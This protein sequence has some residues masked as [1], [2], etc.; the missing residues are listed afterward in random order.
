[1]AFTIPNEVDAFHADQAEP[2]K[3]DIDVLVAA[4]SGQ[5]VLSGAAVT[6][7]GSPDMTVAVAA[8]VVRIGGAPV[9]V[10]SGNVT[11]TSA[12]ATN[13]RFDLIAVDSS[14]TKSA[15]AGSPAAQP[16][17][18]AI[19]AS[20]V[21]LAAVYVPATDTTIASNQITD[22]RAIVTPNS[23]IPISSTAAT[24]AGA[25]QTLPDENAS[26]QIRLRFTVPEWWNGIS[27]I[28]VRTIWF[29]ASTGLV[30]LETQ[31]DYWTE[32][33]EN[34]TVALQAFTNS[35]LTWTTGSRAKVLTTTIAAASVA[36]NRH[37]QLAFRRNTGDANTGNLFFLGA[38]INQS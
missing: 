24:V 22:K 21:I 23:S 5:G 7:Q 4:L 12:D 33:D 37:F 35:N 26:N 1:M 20:S 29:A 9:Q 14:G 32:V 30:D 28:V 6:A 36:A 13:P 38:R 3:V 16:V 15:V 8:G 18:P 27:D 2:D 11:I 10:A 34:A 17:F 19:P 25:D 31:I